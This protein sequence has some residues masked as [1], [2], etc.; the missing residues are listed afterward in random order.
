MYCSGLKEEG[1]VPLHYIG[2]FL[3]SLIIFASTT[4]C[5]FSL[6]SSPVPSSLG[7]WEPSYFLFLFCC[8]FFCQFAFIGRASEQGQFKC[9]SAAVQFCL[10]VSVSAFTHLTSTSI[11]DMSI[12][13]SVTSSCVC[14]RKALVWAWTGAKLC[15]GWS[16]PYSIWCQRGSQLVPRLCFIT[17]HV[18]GE[19]TAEMTF[20]KSPHAGT[21]V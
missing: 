14:Q 15:V 5:A 18:H 16:A 7:L 20:N 6:P 17:E 10:C 1:Q 12:L 2:T 11:L 13:P 3:C 4:F 21:G 9:L 19:R 8:F